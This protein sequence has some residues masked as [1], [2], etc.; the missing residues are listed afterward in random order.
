MPK[1]KGADYDRGHSAP[2]KWAPWSEFRDGP[3]ELVTAKIIFVEGASPNVQ[4]QEAF[5]SIRVQNDPEVSSI[6]CFLAATRCKDDQNA[7]AIC[8]SGSPR[9]DPPNVYMLEPGVDHLCML[10]PIGRW[11]CSEMFWIYCGS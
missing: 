7:A 11:Y 9:L 4:E 10:D 1:G 5:N 2:C 8:T 3:T 6:F